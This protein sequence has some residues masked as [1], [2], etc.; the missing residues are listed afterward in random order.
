VF[1]KGDQ[2]GSYSLL[3]KIGNGAFG[4]VWLAEEK[5]AITTHKVA[6]KLPNEED[7]DLEAIRQEADVWENVKGHPNILPIIKAD[8]YEGQIYIASEY[9]PDRSL[10]E[11]LKDHGGKAPT[12]ETAV[13]MTKGILAGLEHLHSKGVIHRDLKP[14]NILLQADTPRIA[15]FGIE[16]LAKSASTT[17]SQMSAGTPSYMAPECFY[18]VRSEQT[19]I[20]AIGVMFHKLLSGKLPFA[21]PDQVSV[22]NSILNG[23]PNIDPEIPAELQKIIRKAL[24]KDTALRYQTAAEFRQDLVGFN[25]AQLPAEEKVVVPPVDALPLLLEKEEETVVRPK[26]VVPV[27]A[28]VPP[29]EYV[30]PAAAGNG[31]TIMLAIAGSLVLAAIA[32]WAALQYGSE[33]ETQPKF[34]DA[35][36]Q[37]NRDSNFNLERGRI[38]NRTNG[39]QPLDDRRNSGGS[40]VVVP[41]Y[42][43]QSSINAGETLPSQTGE[44]NVVAPYPVSPDVPAS[45]VNIRPRTQ[46]SDVP[47]EDATPLPLPSQ[48]PATLPNDSITPPAGQRQRNKPTPKP[49]TEETPPPLEK[50]NPAS[51]N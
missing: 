14:A 43:N 50:S 21:H 24:Q 25:P 1:Q 35:T 44:T 48:T 13:E 20:W 2:I 18:S 51:G 11:W 39:L 36:N 6:L 46:K 22:M 5:T 49:T 8:I 27:A 45:N 28:S 42:E 34:S 12:V 37:S 30:R 33:T 15:D 9:A 23:E 29:I 7:V 16:R 17:N 47:N 19:D 32:V 10:S 26:V 3:E 38:D 31:K 41:G 40:T 4:E